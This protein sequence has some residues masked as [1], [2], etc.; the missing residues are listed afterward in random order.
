MKGHAE[1]Q[2]AHPDPPTRLPS[3]GFSSASQYFALPQR[4][5]TSFSVDVSKNLWSG[6]TAHTS[7]PARCGDNKREGALGGAFS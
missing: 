7:V 1:I 2:L 3:S 6:E 4:K 5:I